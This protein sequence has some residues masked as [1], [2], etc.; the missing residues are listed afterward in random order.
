MSGVN[1]ELIA[2]DSNGNRS[3]VYRCTT[4]E[5]GKCV[6]YR[7][8]FGKLG[9]CINWFEA[10]GNAMCN[11]EE[12]TVSFGTLQYN[13]YKANS[14]PVLNLYISCKE[15]IQQNYFPY[16]AYAKNSLDGTPLNDVDIT[17]YA[18]LTYD[19]TMQ[20]GTLPTGAVKPFYLGPVST[21]PIGYVQ[22]NETERWYYVGDHQ[23]YLITDYYIVNW[24]AKAVRNGV[25][26]TSPTLNVYETEYTFYFDVE[27]QVKF[28]LITVNGIVG[29]NTPIGSGCEARIVIYD[30]ENRALPYTGYTD[31]SG[32]FSLDSDT[33]EMEY[34]NVVPVAYNC[35]IRYNNVMKE[36][37]RTNF[38]PDN[39]YYSQT[40]YFNEEPQNTGYTLTGYVY[41]RRNNVV[42]PVANQLVVFSAKTGKDIIFRAEVLTND[43]G[44]ATISVPDGPWTGNPQSAIHDIKKWTIYTNYNGSQ[45]FGSNGVN[46]LAN[47]QYSDIIYVKG[48]DKWN[49][50]SVHVQ[51]TYPTNNG[52]YNL[53]GAF[54]V[55]CGSTLSNGTWNYKRTGVTDANGNIT[56]QNN[57]HWVH[58]N[59]TPNGDINDFNKWTCYGSYGGNYA[60]GTVLTISQNHQELVIK[61]AYPPTPP[62]PPSN[63]C[64]H[65]NVPEGF[66]IYMD[67]D[68]KKHLLTTQGAQNSHGGHVVIRP[69]SAYTENFWNS[70]DDFEAIILNRDTNPIYKARFETPYIENNIHLY[71]MKNYVFP[72]VDNSGTPD[73]TTGNFNGYLSSLMKIA[74][75]YDE[76]CANNL[77]R[78]MTHDSIKNL[79]WSFTRRK[80]G[81]EEDI[82]DF[83]YSRMK[84]SLMVEARIYDDIKRYADNIKSMN[85]I[86]YDERNNVPDYFLS[87]L[88]ELNGFE[89]NNID[90]FSQETTDVI[91]SGTRSKDYDFKNFTC[92]L[93]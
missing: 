80:D 24:Y 7:K 33:F 61:T 35:S 82:D 57:S 26:L 37:I 79:D 51:G 17:F 28:N 47:N 10:T 59:G 75:Y 66:Y 41:S 15:N 90:T 9:E 87:D 62:S 64:D 5:E 92:H 16:I 4:N 30:E 8:S 20:G 54:V 52:S 46:V 48:V 89:P 1:I 32:S 40:L 45:V 49:E 56:F 83:D 14:A 36:G 29:T 43:N 55:V 69:K 67:G 60:N 85:Y 2:Q 42:N 3:D 65:I 53:E 77:W 50:L 22:F 70:L 84:A 12:T 86:S 27:D 25:E 6:V 63:N 19:E 31:N 39:K 71:K 91:Y 72:T 38:V 18:R 11:K 13:C 44:V 78:M 74:E 93:C 23:Q 58:I 81:V 76:Y 88:V 34:G 73:L 68:G 21:D